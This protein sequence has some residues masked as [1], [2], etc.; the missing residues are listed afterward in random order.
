MNLGMAAGGD[1]DQHV[2]E[3]TDGRTYLAWK[4]DDNNVGSATT[5][6]WLQEIKFSNGSVTQVGS[7]RVIMD[8][9]GLW[10]VDSWISGGSLVEGP[11]IIKRNG[12]YYLFFASG[13]YCQDTYMEGVARS[14]SVWGPYE[15]M[16]VPLL[17][18]GIVGW[19]QSGGTWGKVVGPGHA[20]LL[21][22]GAD[23]WRIVWHASVGENCVRYP[24]INRLTF[25]TDGWPLV[26]F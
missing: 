17:S 7:A 14:T 16:K 18:N 25:G 24:F 10:W 19:A 6:L 13:K 20:A 11:E 3:D 1:I 2:F 4:T 5:R 12:L 21:Q 15:K 8:S 26:D 22:T 23:A 9:T